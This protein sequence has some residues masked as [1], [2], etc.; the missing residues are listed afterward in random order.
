MHTLTYV[1][2]GIF[3]LVQLGVL[4]WFAA[5]WPRMRREMQASRAASR[6]HVARMAAIADEALGRERPDE[7]GEERG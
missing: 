7:K 2:V 3:F 4:V 1:L 5:T 6:R